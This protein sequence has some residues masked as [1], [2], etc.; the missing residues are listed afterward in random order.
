MRKKIVGFV[1]IVMIALVNLYMIS[2]DNAMEQLVLLQEIESLANGDN[3][4]GPCGS[5]SFE[6]RELKSYVCSDGSYYSV[7]ASSPDYSDCCNPDDE[8]FC[9]VGTTPNDTILNSPGSTEVIKNVCSQIQ[10]QYVT[11]LCYKTC[12]RCG[13]S[14]NLCFD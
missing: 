6:G 5:I 14:Y 12:T 3:P 7:C 4:E 1:A 9:P 8:T 13:I 10:H 2:S 11:T